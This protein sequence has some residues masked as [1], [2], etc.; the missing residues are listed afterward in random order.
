M[1]L[2]VGAAS[3]VGQA[4][5]RNE[6]SYLASHPLYVVADGLGGHRG[7]AV[8]SSLAVEVLSAMRDDRL[9]DHIR[10]ANREVFERQAA[11]RSLAG[12]GTT[13]TA[14]LVDDGTVR[15]AHIGDSRAYLLR[16]G[17]LRRLTEDHSLVHRMVTEGRISEEE[18]DVHPQRNIVTRALGLDGDIDVDEDALEVREGDRLLLCSD[19]LTTM[20][21][22][23]SVQE[24]LETH[25]DPQEAAD[26]LVS[27]AN[28]AGGL[29]NITVVVMD[30]GAGDGAEV[31]APGQGGAATD[32][33]AADSDAGTPATGRDVTGV[34][35]RP[36]P[37][38]T[39]EREAT[40]ERKSPRRWRRVLLWVGV[41]LLVVIGGLTAFGLYVN[42]QW[43]VGE[44][45]GHVTV[46]RGIPSEVAGFDL[47]RSVRETRI[48]AGSAER[49]APYRDLENGITV[50][51]EAAANGLI[52]TICKDLIAQAQLQKRPKG[53]PVP[54]PEGC[55]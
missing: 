34:I 35:A 31:L 21:R 2:R 6:D 14:A 25:A 23:A 39:E 48:P 9:A 26:A 52:D 45:N 30:F 17:E 19:G 7:G 43:Y 16:D 20:M 36:V 54:K 29:D 50:S 40:P 44:R 18:A 33:A 15:L 28:R 4:R 13:V 55:S 1:K 53:A 12:M 41:A 51:N 32:T 8:A 38:D 3:D 10:E 11:D 22:D 42:G 5:Q 49:L 47:S 37:R 46:F 24:I 27:S